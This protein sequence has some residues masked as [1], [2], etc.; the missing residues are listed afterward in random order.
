MMR[1][2]CP[3]AAVDRR[4][5]DSLRLWNAARKS[6][7]DPDLFRTNAQSAI[8]ALRSVTWILQKEKGQLLGFDAWYGAK[9]VEMRADPVLRWLIDARNRIEKQGDLVT[10]S[11]VRTTTYAGWLDSK[12]HD[13]ELPPTFTAAMLASALAKS[14][15]KRNHEDGTLIRVERRWVDSELHQF[16][17][18]E[19]LTHVY[20][21]LQLL[22]FEAHGLFHEPLFNV[23][24]FHEQLRSSNFVLPDEMLHPFARH[25]WIDAK[26]GKPLHVDYGTTTMDSAE[27]AQKNER[28]SPKHSKNNANSFSR[29]V[30]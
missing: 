7:F 15:G 10:R 4:L 16:E 12:A 22:V 3:L 17:I 27:A 9:Q 21:K 6:Y 24:G 11:T 25:Q 30:R 14:L 23:C 13:T 1:K 5:A 20:G 19:A 8:Q 2:H 28:R 18:L 29:G 26:S